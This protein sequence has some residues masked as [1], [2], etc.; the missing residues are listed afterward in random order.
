MGVKH[1]QQSQGAGIKHLSRLERGG[2]FHRR[3]YRRN[4]IINGMIRIRGERW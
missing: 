2:R 3:K 4:D 1:S